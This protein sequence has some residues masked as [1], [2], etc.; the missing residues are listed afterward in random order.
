[1]NNAVTRSI[2]SVAAAGL[3]LAG[4]IAAAPAASAEQAPM[5]HSKVKFT[6]RTDRVL[7]KAD[8]T[9][10]PMG[11]A[12]LSE[13]SD[14]HKVV[15]FDVVRSNPRHTKVAHDGG[16]RFRTEDGNLALTRWRMNAK[17][18]TVSAVINKSAR[19]DFFTLQAAPRHP[20]GTYR[21]VFNKIGAGNFDT[22]LDTTSFN[23]GDRFGLV[24]LPH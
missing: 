8:V 6:A 1:M 2:T 13:N 10:T 22:I 16:I 9:V 14:G 17:K 18:G 7:E 20:K 15:R 11:S 4:A 19:A 24:R 3:L 5:G 21:V 23:V 12:R